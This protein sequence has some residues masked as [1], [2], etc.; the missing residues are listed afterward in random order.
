MTWTPSSLAEIGAN[1]ATEVGIIVLSVPAWRSPPS[2]RWSGCIGAA[3]CAT[4][5]E[6]DHH[7]QAIFLPAASPLSPVAR[8]GPGGRRHSC[9]W[10]PGMNPANSRLFASGS[11][12]RHRMSMHQASACHLTHF[13]HSELG[14]EAAA[15][16]CR[17]EDNLFLMRA[18]WSKPG[19]SMAGAY[20]AADAG[21]EEAIRM[22][23]AADRSRRHR[24]QRLHRAVC[25]ARRWR[26]WLIGQVARARAASPPRWRRADCPAH[27]TWDSVVASQI[28]P[29]FPH[30]AVMMHPE[31]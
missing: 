22:V 6:R 13:P 24:A 29:H 9:A 15:L 7:Q 5:A 30:P 10:R 18:W 8:A 3:K 2:R 12:D 19:W 16:L 14:R 31:R 26:H 17:A 4:A 25:R 20:A 11:G 1:V 21:T 28:A 23:G 27:G